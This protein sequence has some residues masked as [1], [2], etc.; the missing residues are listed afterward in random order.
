M[1]SDIDMRLAWDRI[2]ARYQARAQ[3]STGAAHYGPWAPDEND[4]RL[5]GDVRGRRI[6]ELG[7]GGGQ[8]SIAF[9]RQGA[10]VVGMDLSGRQLAFARGLA[11]RDGVAVRWEQGDIADLSRF[12]DGSFDVVFSAYA[13][14][15]VG[16]IERCLAGVSRVL[17]RPDGGAQVP[18]GQFVFSLDHPFRD[19]FWDEDRDEESMQPA[20]SYFLRGAMEWKF[21]P[22]PAVDDERDQQPGSPW[23]RSYH[24][25]VGDWVALLHGV[26]LQVERL[27]EPEPV[28]TAEEETAWAGSYDLEVARLIPQ[29]IIFATRQRL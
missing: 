5:L 26:G 4:L 2:S 22:L 8:C 14:Q 21:G 27:L 16:P 17:R 3:L 15:Y 7:C 6:L 11:A 1:G 9:A 19:C 24:R 29:T 10:T 13:F 18:G 28:L 20:R 25:T 12:A 23:M